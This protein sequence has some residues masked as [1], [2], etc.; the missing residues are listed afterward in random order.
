MIVESNMKAPCTLI[1]NISKHSS[2]AFRSLQGQNLGA[3][4]LQIMVSCVLFSMRRLATEPVRNALDINHIYSSAHGT[5]F[6]PTILAILT[7]HSTLQKPR[8][9]IMA[10]SQP[11]SDFAKKSFFNR[12]F[13]AHPMQQQ[14]K[15]ARENHDND[16]EKFLRAAEAEGSTYRKLKN[17]FRN[18]V[19]L[20]Q[21]GRTYGGLM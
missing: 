18:D 15:P 3:K 19:E 5:Q 7:F 21:Q 10:F 2:K 6:S 9:Q 17:Y 8:S 1:S 20:G 4:K 14:P 11:Q 12:L 16:Y 13:S